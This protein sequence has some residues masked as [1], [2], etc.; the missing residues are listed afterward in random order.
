MKDKTAKT[1]AD[2]NPEK[3]AD[4]TANGTSVLL[5]LPNNMAT[6]LRRIAKKEERS[7]TT[8]AIRAI[9]QYFKTEHN[10]EIANDE[11]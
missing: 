2:K 4:R 5:R 10:I 1:T 9:R 11:E 3:V 7:I 8:V 6:E